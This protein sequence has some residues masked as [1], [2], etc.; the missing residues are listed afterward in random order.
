MPDKQRSTNLPWEAPDATQAAESLALRAKTAQ[1]SEAHQFALL[2]G[3]IHRRLLERL[4]LANLDKMERETVV[5]AIRRV[6]HELLTQ[7]KVP[8]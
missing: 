8:L 6:V 5:E 4:N 1:D 7:E 3:R 2:K